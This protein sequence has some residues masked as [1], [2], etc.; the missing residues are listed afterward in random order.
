MGNG[1][2]L[3]SFK[4]IFLTYWPLQ[5]WWSLLYAILN[6]C[7]RGNS[8]CNF[9]RQP[10]W[11]C[12][13]IIYF[14]Y[15]QYPWVLSVLTSL[16]MDFEQGV[17]WESVRS[18]APGRNTLACQIL[19]VRGKE[20]LLCSVCSVV[21]VTLSCGWM[22]MKKSILVSWGLNF[23]K[24]HYSYYFLCYSI[25]PTPNTLIHKE[26]TREA[27]LL[28]PRIVAFSKCSKRKAVQDRWG[29]MKCNISQAKNTVSCTFLHSFQ[30]SQELRD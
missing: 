20:V 6:T 2:R 29:R 5:W 1:I 16:R 13:C 28:A 10:T 26:G 11:K 24:D 3:R 17:R 25:C 14:P 19:L 15:K 12:L 18:R 8:I 22:H 9:M 27:F 23:K 7:R 30:D 21:A 4:R